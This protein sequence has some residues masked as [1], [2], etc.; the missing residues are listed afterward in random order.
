M[1]AFEYTIEQWDEEPDEGKVY[2]MSVFVGLDD[3][4][5]EG[6]GDVG[7]VMLGSAFLKSYV[8]VWDLMGGGMSCE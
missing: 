8:T 3:E 4:E 2:C 1:S 5:G 6:D 7:V